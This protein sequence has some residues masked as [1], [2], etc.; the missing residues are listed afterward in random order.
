MSRCTQKELNAFSLEHYTFINQIFGDI[1]VRQIIAE[2]YRS[3]VWT[4]QVEETG[5]D[6]NNS[7]HHVLHKRQRGRNGKV[8]KWCSVDEGYQNLGVNTYDTLCQSYTLMTYL[9]REIDTDMKKRQMQMVQM[10]ME[11][12]KHPYFKQQLQGI[13]ELMQ[14]DALL[15]RDYRDPRAPHFHMSY[16]ELNAKILATLDNWKRFGY[17]YFIKDGTCP[18]RR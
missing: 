9:N 17:H 10:Y 3:N 16:D 11:I 2:A 14:G 7:S 6:F 8:V 4:F 1:S 5:A 12:L 15:W 18:T 13:V